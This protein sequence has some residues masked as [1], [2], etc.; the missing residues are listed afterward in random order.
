[1]IMNAIHTY[2]LSLL[3]GWRHGVKISSFDDV[4]LWGIISLMYNIK[5]RL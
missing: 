1:M 2:N 3:I 5:H 4:K